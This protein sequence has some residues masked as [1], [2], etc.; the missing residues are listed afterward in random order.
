MT[1]IIYNIYNSICK[2]MI[3]TIF[4]LGMFFIYRERENRVKRKHKILERKT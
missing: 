1:H 4:Y 2:R 3:L